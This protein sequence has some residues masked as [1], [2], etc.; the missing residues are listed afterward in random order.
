MK[1]S[2]VSSKLIIFFKE[3]AFPYFL[4]LKIKFAVF[5]EQHTV[6]SPVVSIILLTLSSSKN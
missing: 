4:R 5:E 3:L 1:G 2:S 6:S